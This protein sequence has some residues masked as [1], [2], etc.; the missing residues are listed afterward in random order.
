[1]HLLR[2][3]LLPCLYSSTTSQEEGGCLPYYSSQAISEYVLCLF[4]KLCL[5]HSGKA[6]LYTHVVEWK[7]QLSL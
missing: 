5:L 3:Q 7:G 6:G 1:M 4:S 2:V